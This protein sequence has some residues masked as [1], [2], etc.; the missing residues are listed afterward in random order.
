MAEPYNYFFLQHLLSP[1]FNNFLFDYFS[2]YLSL[3]WIYPLIPHQSSKLLLRIL[4]CIENLVNFYFPKET[5][6]ISLLGLLF[7]NAYINITLS[8]KSPSELNCLATFLYLRT[9]V[10]YF[11]YSCTAINLIPHW[12]RFVFPVLY[13]SKLSIA[14]NIFVFLH[15]FV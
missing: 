9:S 6:S 8:E 12:Q 3:I 13:S 5:S 15:S 10:W 4:R 7:S 11:K 2:L 1:E 14:V